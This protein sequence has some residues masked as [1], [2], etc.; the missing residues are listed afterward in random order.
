MTELDAQVIAEFRANA[1]VVTDA[2]GGHF[3]DIHLLVLHHTGR[4][5]GTQY[6]TPLLYV[7]DGDRYILVGSNGGNA[8]EPAWVANVAAMTE[9]LIEVGERSLRAKPTLLREGPQWARLY[10][11]VVSYWPAILQYQTLTTRTFPLIVLDI[12]GTSDSRRAPALRPAA[13]AKPEADPGGRLDTKEKVMSDTAS[14]FADTRDMYTVHSMMRREF[15]LLPALVRSVE[16]GDSAR[17]Q[18]VAD[19]IKLLSLVLN[20]HHSAED[21]VLWP[22]LLSRAPKEIDPVVH[23]VEEQHQKIDTLTDHVDALVAPWTSGA[24]LNDRDALSEALDCLA[25][26]LY[27]HMQLEERL[28]LPVVERHIFASEWQKMVEEGATKIPAEAVP[29]VFGML[30]YE[31]GSDAVPAEARAVLAD[32]APRAYAAHCERLH[33]TSTPPQPDAAM[34]AAPS[35]RLTSAC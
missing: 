22:K 6:V 3:K 29:L 16:A 32:E 12:H 9:V 27:G 26:L 2:M 35:Q 31:G 10:A 33:G 13:D 28:I 1:G 23:L 25:V 4:S 34:P 19:H 5:S 8:K 30:M 14:P 20:E 18:V 17:A 21:A 7:E 11:A 15:A 24:G